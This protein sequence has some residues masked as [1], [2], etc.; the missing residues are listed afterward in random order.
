MTTITRD[1]CKALNAEVN[2]ALSAIAAKHGLI[3][4]I[5]GGS[6]G[7]ASFKP[8]VEFLVPGGT[9]GAVKREEDN[10]NTLAG[11]YGL[12]PAW[13][14]KTFTA[15]NG[16]TFRVVGLL[17]GRSKNIVKVVRVRDNS[18]RVAP[19]GFLKTGKFE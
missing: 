5:N 6:F 2:A 1:T 7:P 9:D 15:Y 10:W 19:V 13:L 4:K 18:P 3:V 11:L 14:G 17:T 8:R 16:E 12:D